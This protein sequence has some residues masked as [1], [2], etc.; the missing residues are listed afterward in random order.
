MS[1]N[2][3]WICPLCGVVN[4]P[5]VEQ[6]TCRHAAVPEWPPIGSGPKWPTPVYRFNSAVVP[7]VSPVYDG[8]LE[9]LVVK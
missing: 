2:E 9:D 4:A 5:W 6:C 1:E 8:L 7:A 3:G